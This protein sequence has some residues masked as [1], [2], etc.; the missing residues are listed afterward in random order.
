MNYAGTAGATTAAYE[1]IANATK[2]SGAIISIKPESFLSLLAKTEKPLVVYSKPAFLSKNYKYI[3][4]YKGLIFFTIN[5]EPLHLS[6]KAEVIVAKK[7][8]IPS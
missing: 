1:S 2:A 6:S 8:W 3:T 7:I 5:Y 4:A